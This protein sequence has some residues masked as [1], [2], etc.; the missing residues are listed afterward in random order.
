MTESDLKDRAQAASQRT[1]KPNGGEVAGREP[2]ALEKRQSHLISLLNA[3]KPEIQKALPRHISPE[4]IARIA[5]TALRRTPNLAMCTPESFLGALLTSSQLGLEV[6]TPE[7]EAYLIPYKNECTLVVG[8]RGLTKLFWQHP[9]AKHIDAQAVYDGDEFDYAYGLDPF[10]KHKPAPD[11]RRG[12]TVRYYYAVATLQ[13]GGSAFVVLTP[14]QVKELRGGK[15]G[16]SGDIADPMRWMERK[17]ALKQVCKILPKTV[18]L[19]AALAADENVRTD[20]TGALDE[21]QLHAPQVIDVAPEPQPAEK[22]PPDAPAEPQQPPADEPPE[23][24]QPRAEDGLDAC[25][26]CG[27]VPRHAPADCPMGPEIAASE[28]AE[29]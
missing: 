6:N 28:N 14:N 25:P 8:Y 26:A 7:G 4:R 17:T 12:A 2:T 27:D 11:G 23:Q 21:M 5:T 1:D 3:M 19:Q 9:Q 20:Y 24:E 10:L 29:S 18:E 22:P 13:G 15:E 16:P